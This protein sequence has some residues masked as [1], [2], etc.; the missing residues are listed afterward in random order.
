[1]QITRKGKAIII[2]DGYT[3]ECRDEAAADKI[4]EVAEHAP[5]RDSLYCA[6]RHYHDDERHLWGLS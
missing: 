4:M 6:T 2:I 5:D 1:M 3:I